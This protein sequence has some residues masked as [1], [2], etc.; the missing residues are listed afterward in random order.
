ME[1][2][3]SFVSCTN[4]I[5]AVPI[6]FAMKIALLL[7]FGYAGGVNALD[8]SAAVQHLKLTG[9]ILKVRSKRTRGYIW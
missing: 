8:L 2:P 6:L 5:A 4:A 1:Q 7:G 3:F 9:G